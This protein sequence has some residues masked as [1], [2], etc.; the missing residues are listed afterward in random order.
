MLRLILWRSSKKKETGGFAPLDPIRACALNP[1][2]GCRQEMSGALPLVAG[3]W[4]RLKRDRE[5][6]GGVFEE[7]EFSVLADEL[8]EVEEEDVD[9]E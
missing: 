3:C 9:S 8:G 1:G 7:D 5:E 6:E 2:S 4:G